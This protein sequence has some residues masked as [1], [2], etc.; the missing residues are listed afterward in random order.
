MIVRT[1]HIRRL[2]QRVTK[3]KGGRRECVCHRRIHLHIVSLVELGLAQIQ[4]KQT[5]HIATQH[6]CQKLSVRNV[7]H[8]GAHNATTL[9]EQFLVAP[10]HV[11]R[12]QLVRNA[13]VLRHHD[14]VHRQQSRLFAASCVARADA[15]IRERSALA[16]IVAW[17]A[18]AKVEASAVQ[19]AHV[20]AGSRAARVNLRGIQV[21]G[22]L[23]GLFAPRKDAIGT[24]RGG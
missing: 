10:V 21:G 15:L 12:G 4:I 5:A 16:H 14:M 23:V 22:H 18:A 24:L 13:I 20:V 19:E 7:L 9:L 11:Q 1:P 6:Q 8:N 17:G 2:N 3:P